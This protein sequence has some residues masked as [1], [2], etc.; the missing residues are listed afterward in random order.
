LRARA[1]QVLR[2]LLARREQLA[3]GEQ[4]PQH[5][6]GGVLI[7]AAVELLA[8]GLL[9]R[10]VRDLAVDDAGR[11][12]LELERRRRQPEVGQLHL[13]GVRD[14]DVRRR[15]V[16]VDQLQ[17]R[18]GVG[19]G[20]PAAQLLDDVHRDVDGER[21]PLTGAAVPDR[22]QVAALDEVH[23]QEQ[24]AVDLAGVEHRDQVAVGQLDDDLG[25]VAEPRHVLGV[26]Q[27]RQDGLDH[28]HALE[29]AIAGHRQV[30]RT[31]PALRQRP[32]QV[33]LPEAPRVLV[34]QLTRGGHATRCEG[35]TRAHPDQTPDRSPQR[36]QTPTSVP[37]AAPRSFL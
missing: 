31:H 8:A 1:K 25:L 16:A 20:Q 22:A 18:E 14:Q 13:A 36:R 27:V 33:V 29:A 26:G 32:E 12:L 2:L 11:G 37:A 24:L 28:H 15:D 4:L 7:A 34:E 17:V 23:R 3:P 19:V 35:T 9:G 5:D 30:Q 6:R 21:H 10:H